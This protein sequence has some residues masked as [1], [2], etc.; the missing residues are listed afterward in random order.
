[1]PELVKRQAR[2]KLAPFNLKHNRRLVP[3]KRHL[4]ILRARL[5][6]RLALG[7]GP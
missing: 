7:L 3:S 1:M 5:T 2:A 4:R 6:R